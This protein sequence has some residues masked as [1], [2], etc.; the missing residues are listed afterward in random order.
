MVGL[1]LGALVSKLGVPQ[2]ISSSSP[3]RPQIDR[4][5]HART[6]RGR[7][8]SLEPISVLGYGAIRW[9][10]IITVRMSPTVGRAGQNSTSMLHIKGER[11]HFYQERRSG[12]DQGES[13]VQ[14]VCSH[15]GQA[16]TCGAD[17]DLAP[18]DLVVFLAQPST[19]GTLAVSQNIRYN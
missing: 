7:I 1:F 3:E 4:G 16:F 13:G 14:E 19:V 17:M 15:T 11:P 8:F 9:I 18:S 2:R 5:S 10:G 12:A 6:Q